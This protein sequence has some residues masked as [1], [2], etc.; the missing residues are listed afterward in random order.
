MSDINPDTSDLQDIPVALPMARP[1][2]H[3]PELPAAPRPHDR[4]AKWWSPR[5]MTPWQALGDLLIVGAMFFIP[6][7]ATGLIDSGPTDQRVE[8]VPAVRLLLANTLQMAIIAVLAIYLTYRSGEPLSSLGLGTAPFWS[9]LGAALGGLIVMYAALLVLALVVSLLAGTSSETMTEPTR[10]IQDLLGV[11]SWGMIFFV[12]ASAGILE[13]ILF[14]GF[15]L[16]RLRVILRSWIAAVVVGIVLFASLHIWEGPWAVMLI[17]PVGLVL[18]IL[19]IRRRNLAASML[20]HFLFNF[21]QLTLMRF[22][23]ESPEL[24][25]MILQE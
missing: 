11:P 15:L 6:H 25:K 21:L 5:R 17:L 24:R 18:S 4:A 22:V 19:F 20:A 14:R 2:V 9:T 16:T 10:E 8:S 7:L 12:A 3:P 13:E 23:L 1:I